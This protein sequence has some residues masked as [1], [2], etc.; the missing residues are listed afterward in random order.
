MHPKDLFKLNGKAALVT[1][2]TK[3]IGRAI[4]ETLAA[5]GASVVISS[6][7][8]E[9]CDE[10]VEAIEKQGGKA[11]AVPANMS[12]TGDVKALG[13]K[14]LAAWGR[15]DILVCNAA[16]NPYYGPMQNVTQDAY[17][18]TMGTNVKNNLLLC[19]AILPNMA[20]R[21][22]GAVIIVSSIGGFKGHKMLGIYGLSKAADMQ[23]ARNLAVE[24]GE[25][26]IR[27]NCIA[28]GIVKT[29]MARVLWEDPERHAQALKTYPI[30]RL[31]EPMD[32]A[33]TALL[34]ASPAGSWITGQTITVDGGNTIATGGYS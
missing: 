22:D 8:S 26:N 14:A 11:V 7:K 28:P 34:L 18:K 21:K 19:N 20:G 1:G 15:I 29:D 30:G 2:A 12:R 23:L 3:G 16:V 5:Y 31:A 6:R 32:I 9:A 27:A 24:W 10:T 25:H 4:A 13:E 33:G 17:D